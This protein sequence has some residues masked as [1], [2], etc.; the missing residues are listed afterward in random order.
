MQVPAPTQVPA[1]SPRRV[2]VL[3][4]IV[5][6][7]AVA[8]GLV[9][10][11]MLADRLAAIQAR[12]RT[13]MLAARGELAWLIRSVG[14]GVFALTLACGASISVSCKRAFAASE[15]PPPGIWS[16]GAARVETGPRARRYAKL[17]MAL[18]CALIALSLIG[19]GLVWYAS[20]VLYA[21]RAQ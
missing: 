12:S 10:Q 8:L 1:A 3:R 11:N 21:C 6:L 13:E 16:W 7:G 14:C 9:L 5:F 15:F 17:G 19:G 18:G 20:A 4:V 2:I